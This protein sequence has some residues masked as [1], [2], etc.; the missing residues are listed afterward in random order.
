MIPRGSFARVSF[1]LVVLASVIVHFEVANAAAQSSVSDNARTITVSL[2]GPFN[3]CTFLDGGANPTSDA[4]LDLIRPSA[5]LTNT[6]GNLVGEG[7]S[8]A[9]AEL[10]SLQPETVVY[11]IAPGQHWSN[12][13]V[14]DGRDLVAWW[15]RARDLASVQSDGYRAIRTLTLSDHALKVTAVFATPYANWNL[16]FRDVE[17]RSGAP[18]CALSNLMVNPS[19]GPYRVTNVTA[20]RIVLTMNPNWPNDPNRFGRVILTTNGVIPSGSTTPFANYSLA[21]N[22]AQEQALSAHPSVLSHIGTSSNI[23][24]ITFAPQGPL[25][26]SLAVREALSW[27]LNRQTLINQLFGAVT[28]SP[29]IAASAIFSQ[30]QSAYPGFNGSGP[31]TQTTTTSVPSTSGPVPTLVDCPTCA[32]NA[33]RAAA[34]RHTSSGWVN[35]DGGAFKLQLAVGPSTVD[36]ATAALVVSQWHNAGIAATEVDV[37][38]DETAAQ[39]AAANVVDAAIFARP[40]LTAPSYTARS[41]SGPAYA[42][43][44]P[45]GMRSSTVTAF[46]KSANSNFNPVAANATWLMLDQSIMT[47]FLVRPL[48]TSPSLVEWASSITG[49]VGSL[50]VSGFLDQETNWTSISISHS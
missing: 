23:E 3:G 19:L 45:S 17:A 22:R 12:G 38:S 6:N 41:W 44:F 26:R 43:T 42:D 29:S 2:P 21:V 28:F 14:F 27:S 4:V 10:T 30:G 5:F 49:I 31:S 16:L 7:G 24:E 34:F 35:A 13:A 18:G 9:S 25:T 8:L 50:S 36:A 46:F 15:L 48:F 11:T 39:M 20:S 37:K 40:T 1:A 47:S 32:F 33:L